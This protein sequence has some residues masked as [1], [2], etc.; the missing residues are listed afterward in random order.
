MVAH[1][2]IIEAHIFQMHN[3]NQCRSA[4]P[5]IQKDMLVY[6][7][8]K[9][10]MLPKGRA[11]KLCPKWVGSYKVLEVYE[12]TSNYTLELPGALKLQRLHIKFHVSLLWPY[13]AAED[14]M[15]LNHATPEPYDL[16]AAAN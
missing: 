1:N 12:E 6:L 9:N 16:G 8:T 5:D 15:F 3:A 4:S 11:R 7:S 13:R 14:R 2:A 10:L